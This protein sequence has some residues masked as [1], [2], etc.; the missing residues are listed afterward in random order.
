MIT[1][2]FGS[3]NRPYVV[4]LLYFPNLGLPPPGH[5][6]VPIAF[7]LDT[8]ADKTTVFPRDAYRLGVRFGEHFAN[9]RNTP[10]GGVGAPADAYD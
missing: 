3:D 9:H 2:I 6:A 8:G 10:I 1:G 4:G 7:L 5:D